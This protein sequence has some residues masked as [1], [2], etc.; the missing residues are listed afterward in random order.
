MSIHQ[1]CLI[2]PLRHDVTFTG[3]R[4]IRMRC[5]LFG[6]SFRQIAERAGV[7]SATIARIAHRKSKNRRGRDAICALLHLD[8][9]Y[10]FWTRRQH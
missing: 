5:F 4:V 9:K 8:P 10:L 2:D 7:S 6:I 1:G 3:Y